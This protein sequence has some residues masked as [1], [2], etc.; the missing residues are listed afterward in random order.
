MRV[1]RPTGLLSSAEPTYNV[2]LQGLTRIRFVQ[3][4]SPTDVAASN[5]NGLTEYAVTYP[6]ADEK[7]IPSNDN[8]L[9][10]RAAASRLLDRL[11]A[12]AGGPT[13]TSRS[14]RQEVWRRLRALVH[15]TNP[16]GTLWLADVLMGLV[17]TDWEDKLG[18]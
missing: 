3:T 4:P 10:F 9:A 13:G 1:A 12:E 2:T 7:A 5:P 11:D 17:P 15:D 8:V 6:S 18:R 16:Q 14:P